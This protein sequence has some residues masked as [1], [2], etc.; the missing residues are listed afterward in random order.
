MV[1]DGLPVLRS[2]RRLIS[3][4]Q[5]MQMLLCPPMA[6]ILSSDAV[7]HYENAAY[8]VAR[9]TLGDACSSLSCTGRDTPAPSNS[10]NQ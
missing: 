6:S 2:K 7:L 10:G 3:T 5:L 8:S 4:T 9:S 1:D